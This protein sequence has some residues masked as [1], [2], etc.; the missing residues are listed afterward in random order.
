MTMRLVRNDRVASGIFGQIFS[1]DGVLSLFTLEHAYPLYAPGVSPLYAPKVSSG[2]YECVRGIHQLA[3][4]SQPFET[5]EIE[6]VVGHSNILFHSGNVNADSAGC[7]LLGLRQ[8]ADADILESRAAF[9][10][11]MLHLTGLDSFELTVV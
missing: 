6:G 5:F 2:V 7:V 9:Q 1:G 4:M 11:F 8:Q 3:G 10:L